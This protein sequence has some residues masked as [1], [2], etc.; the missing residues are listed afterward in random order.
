MLPE[1]QGIWLLVGWVV[2]VGVY[3]ALFAAMY[4]FLPDKRVAWSTAFRGGVITAVLFMLGRAAIGVYMAYS[5]VAGAFGAFG[6]MI[7]WLLW[8]YYIGIVFLAA[9][10]LVYVLAHARDWP[11]FD[12]GEDADPGKDR[13]RLEIPS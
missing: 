2:G 10:V 1:G 6:S 12:P 11:W 8:V 7:I 4:R 13:R 9:A 5:D 3:T